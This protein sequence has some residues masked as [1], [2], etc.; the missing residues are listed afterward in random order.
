M[1]NG[2]SRAGYAADVSGQAEGLG[3]VGVVAGNAP[4][5][6]TSTVYFRAGSAR[7]PSGWR[8][9]CWF[10]EVRP[11]GS[12]ALATAA[13]AGAEV[14]LVLGTSR[15][16]G[17]AVA[18]RPAI[19]VRIPQY[20]GTWDEI[21]AMASR[22]EALGFD[23]LWVNDHLQSP[24]RITDEPA[25]DALATLAALARPHPPGAPRHGGAVG[26]VPAPGR[27]RQD[28]HDHRRA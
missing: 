23:G 1:L 25:F 3:Y 10:T 4:A 6:A 5:T 13:P 11:S 26:V 8:R 20:G 14:V 28:A 19:G 12:G 21:L 17:T 2:T 7:R 16:R 24:G 22:A 9:T 27:R 18:G 15:A